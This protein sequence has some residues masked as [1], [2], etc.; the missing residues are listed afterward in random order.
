MD[1]TGVGQGPLESIRSALADDPVEVW[2]ISL[3]SGESWRRSGRGMLN[4]SKVQLT[5]ALAEALGSERLKESPRRDGSRMP[6]S[7]VLER[8]L[9]A[10]RV[11]VSSAGNA[12]YGAEGRDHDDAVVSIAMPI[13]AGSLR[14]LAMDG[15]GDS[16]LDGPELESLA[17][18]EALIREAEEEALNREAGI[19]TPKLL[20]EQADFRQK[21]E[22]DPFDACHNGNKPTRSESYA[23]TQNPAR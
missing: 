14:F 8:E 20:A 16:G 11:R 10:F 23:R 17:S 6:N 7:D 9:G 2:G 19:M 12:A 1:A 3:T 13:W 5:G 22:A 21:L 4:V 15:A 18:E